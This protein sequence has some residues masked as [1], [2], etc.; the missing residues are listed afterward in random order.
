M[1][2]LRTLPR[3]VRKL[4]LIHTN[5][6][7]IEHL[8]HGVQHQLTHVILTNNHLA[9][10][11]G[12]TYHCMN[13]RYLDLSHNFLHQLPVLSQ[14][15]K[16]ETL[17]VSHNRISSLDN[18]VPTSPSNLHTLLTSNNCLEH[19]PDQLFESCPKLKV[20]DISKNNCLQTLPG[21]ITE[22]QSL[23]VDDCHALQM[24]PYVVAKNGLAH[25]RKYFRNQK[26]WLA[27]VK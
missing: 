25:I 14:L 11:P 24:P 3:F 2:Q 22:L 10:F 4:A 21:G 12:F 8:L 1:Q 27:K 5:I 26:K 16:L 19:L 15:V 20:L 23:K 17:I 7:F 9:H 13:L 6:G 18:I